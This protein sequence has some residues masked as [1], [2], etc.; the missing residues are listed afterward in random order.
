MASASLQQDSP[1]HFRAEHHVET[2]C[3]HP[4]LGAYNSEEAVLLNAAELWLK[5]L[6]LQSCG[7]AGRAFYDLMST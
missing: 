1:S 3:T 7:A 6:G 2:W 4:G 5:H